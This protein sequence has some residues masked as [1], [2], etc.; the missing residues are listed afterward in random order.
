MKNIFDNSILVVFLCLF[1][2]FLFAQ[3]K[4]ITG[5][6]TTLKNIV[7]VNA[8]IKV[9]SNGM[10]VLTDSMGNFKINC[11][12]KDKIKISANGFY[13]QKV[14]ID[15][16]SKELRIDLK[17]KPKEKNLDVAIGYGHIKE[18]DKSY[19]L[20][21]IVNDN[22]EFSKYS[23]VIELIINSSPSITMSGGGFVIR[24]E[25]SILG[26]SAALIVIDN[27][28]STMS[29]LTSLSPHS[30]KS[31]SVLKGGAAAI[32]GSRGANGVVIITTKRGKD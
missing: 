9:S 13:S 10:E 17:M 28:A 1:S 20:N 3:E 22:F 27:M 18:S 25:S 12:T 32:Y 29:Q 2:S 26:S 24:G 14:K 16:M 31:V 5:N 23:N 4:T 30:V 21:T 6:V 15:K 7:V 8:Q 11:A 19:A